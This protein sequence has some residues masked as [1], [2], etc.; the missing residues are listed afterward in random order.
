M[1]TAA[2]AADAREIADGDEV[3]RAGAA[4]DSDDAVGSANASDG[5]H[6]IDADADDGATSSTTRR[7]RVNAGAARARVGVAVVVGAC[8]L[9]A[10]VR[11]VRGGRDDAGRRRPGRVD[12]RFNRA[13]RKCNRCGKRGDFV[14]VKC[15]RCKRCWYCSQ[16]CKKAAWAM[17]ICECC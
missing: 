11:W 1:A 5:A 12:A 16:E 14:K 7:T 10:L 9:G 15:H 6:R 2:I 17:E 8:A 4:D 13:H 3:H